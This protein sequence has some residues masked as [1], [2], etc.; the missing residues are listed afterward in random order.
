MV[1]H[2]RS[3]GHGDGALIFLSKIL[4]HQPLASRDFERPECCKIRLSSVIRHL[5]GIRPRRPMAC[6]RP[7]P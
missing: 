5:Y 3:G 7:G 6:P 4:S 2:G 1:E